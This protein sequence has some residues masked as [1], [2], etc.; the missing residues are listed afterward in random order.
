[1][2]AHLDDLNELRENLVKH[3]DMDLVSV[4][5]AILVHNSILGSTN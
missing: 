5:K 4:K 3:L 2:T 1:V